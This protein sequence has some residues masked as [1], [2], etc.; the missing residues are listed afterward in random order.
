MSK[1]L[2]KFVFDFK[3]SYPFMEI[4][5]PKD[6]MG[7][8]VTKVNLLPTKVFELMEVIFDHYDDP[9]GDIIFIDNKTSWERYIVGKHGTYRVY[10][11]RGSTSIG[12]NG[13]PFLAKLSDGYQQE[14]LLLQK[15]FEEAW[16]QY[17]V[18]KA[19]HLKEELAERP[20]ANFNRA[21]LSTK[22]LLERATQAGSLLELLVLNATLLDGTLRLGVILATQ[23]RERNDHVNKDMI[24]QEGKKYIGEREIYRMAKDEGILTEDDFNEINALYDFRNVAIHRFFISGVEYNE[25]KPAIARYRAV[26]DKVWIPINEFEERQVK[27]GVGMTKKEDLEL[28]EET[29]KQIYREQYLK[30][31]STKPVAV[32]PKRKFL[33]D[34]DE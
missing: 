16:P 25:I 33:F 12:S 29:I 20:M 18:A 2:K 19:E 32:V 13:L 28:D 24:F 6:F 11:F 21:F 1:A 30:I 3:S 22:I 8:L 31:D 27:E 4:K 10:E 17:E 9:H 26:L 14:A 23:L 7:S 15:A 34:K 5:S